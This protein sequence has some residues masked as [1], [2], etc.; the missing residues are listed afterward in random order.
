LQS[1]RRPTGVVDVRD[2]DQNEEVGVGRIAQQRQTQ[3]QTWSDCVRS[4]GWVSTTAAGRLTPISTTSSSGR[5]RIA[6]ASGFSTDAFASNVMWRSRQ[7]Q[8]HFLGHG[9][10]VR[11]GTS[12]AS[13]SQP[14]EQQHSVAPQFGVATVCSHANGQNHV[15]MQH[16]P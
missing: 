12:L 16:Q 2:A 10:G 5:N 3:S 15:F 1:A 14:P 9:F 7:G 4:D 8:V 6:L 13:A 11:I